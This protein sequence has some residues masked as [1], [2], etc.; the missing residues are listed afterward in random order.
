MIRRSVFGLVLTLLLMVTATHSQTTTPTSTGP[1]AGSQATTLYCLFPL[2]YSNATP[3][4]FT[5]ITASFGSQLTQV[6]LAS[7]ASGILYVES[8]SLHIP[9]KN[10]Q[11]TF[12]PVLTE[13]A[14]TLGRGKLFLAVTYQFFTFN[15]LDGISLKAIP[16]VFNVCNSSGQC[17]ALGTTN[18]VDIKVHQTAIFATYGVLRN[19]DVSVALPWNDVHLAASGYNC[20]AVRANCQGN[21]EQVVPGSAARS[22]SG[23]GDVVVRAKFR[24]PLE[25]QWKFAGGMDFRIASGNEY[26]LLGAGAPGVKPFFS[27]SHDGRVSPHVD[28]AYQ[29]NGSSLLSSTTIGSKAS[30]P[31]SLSYALGVDCGVSKRLTVALDVLGAHTSNQLRLK[32]TLTSIPGIVQPVNDIFISSGSVWNIH[33]AAGIK[34]NLRGGLLVSGNVYW[35]MDHNGLR[36]R[37]VPLG[38][39]SYTF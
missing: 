29:W 12:G 38:G 21:Y 18:R 5:A 28:L 23:L 39:I 24:F 31:S 20:V 19:L 26:N 35:A 34:Y 14:N 22:A 36:N 32:R 27:A 30:L 37:P 33:G 16:V 15:S 25:D 6:P 2:L 13:R 9:V 4:P 10:G 8:A 11:E 17:D 7:P 3:N 1:C